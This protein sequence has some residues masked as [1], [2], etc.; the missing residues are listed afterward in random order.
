M[1][2]HFLIN[3]PPL[4]GGKRKRLIR[5]QDSHANMIRKQ[6]SY[7]VD[8]DS[9]E[10]GDFT[11]EKDTSKDNENLV[12][13]IC[14]IESGARFNIRPKGTRE[15]RQELYKRGSEFIG[16]LLQVKYFELTEN[17]VPRFPTTKSES[18]TSYIRNIVE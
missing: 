5:N 18:Y 10:E 1:R 17:Q 16:S 6:I 2:K 14:E 9:E 8:S 12:V 4:A 7:A 3:T 13:W 11:F 15:E